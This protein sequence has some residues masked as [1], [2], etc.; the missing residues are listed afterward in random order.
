MESPLRPKGKLIM[1]P[2]RR[3]LLDVIRRSK[4]H[5]TAEEILAGIRERM[6]G[7]SRATVYRNLELLTS[8]GLVRKLEGPGTKRRFDGDLSPHGHL[9]CVRCGRFVDVPQGSLKDPPKLPAWISGHKV[10]G[11]RWEILV[12]CSSCLGLRV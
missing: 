8:L 9:C 3:V 2:Q 5:P 4:D 7:V 6:P 12:E 11:Y 1:T 10:L